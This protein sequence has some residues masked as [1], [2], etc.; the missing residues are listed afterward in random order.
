MVDF[1]LV[2]PAES[3]AKLDGPP[4]AIDPVDCAVAADDVAIAAARTT[5]AWEMCNGAAAAA[6]A[7]W[8][9]VVRPSVSASLRFL[10][11]CR[12]MISSRF[13]CALA[14]WR[15]TLMSLR[16]FLLS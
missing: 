11:G 15:L 4:D 9:C 14:L 10:R 5:S 7:V 2:G 1:K 12:N 13:A 8:S 3:G 6:D 16:S